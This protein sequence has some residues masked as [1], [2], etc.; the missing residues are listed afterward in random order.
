MML[1]RKLHTYL[2][3]G[4]S[5]Y[6][7]STHEDLEAVVNGRKLSSA[8]SLILCTEDAVLE[9]DVP[10]A[11]ENLRQVLPKLQPSSTLRFIRVRSLEV[12]RL[13][14]EMPAITKIDGFVLPKITADNFGAYAELFSQYPELYVMPT[15]ETKEA[16]NIT[17]MTKLCQLMSHSAV[18][19]QLLAIRIGGNDLL[20]VIGSR[21]NP[22]RTIYETP[23]SYVISMLVS[24]FKSNGFYLTAPV[25]ESLADMTQL[26]TEVSL[27]LDHGLFGKTAVYPQQIAVIEAQYQVSE[28]DLEMATAILQP[29]APAVFRLHGTMCEPATHRNWAEQIVER[30]AIYGLKMKPVLLERTSHATLAA[31]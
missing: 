19:P 13:C 12:L 17:E 8:R 3:L 29:N 24:V 31:F 2:R 4:A 15:L 5:L 9:K 23:L 28:A 21:R 16:F 18:L 14:C 6:T 20:N 1:D 26:E 22:S 11:L 30:A 25:S 7:P 27:D 10:A